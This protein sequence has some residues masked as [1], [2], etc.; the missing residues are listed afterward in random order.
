MK[1]HLKIVALSAITFVAGSAYA[2]TN[3]NTMNRPTP[4]GSAPSTTMSD[5]ANRPT[6]SGVGSKATG[7]DLAGSLASATD[8]STLQT[9]LVAAGLADKAKE[10][11]PFTVFAP[12]NAAFDKLPAGTLQS[13]TQPASKTKL[14]GILAYHVVPGNVMAADLKD[15][16]KIK[17]VSGGTLTVRKKGSAVMLVDAKG[18]SAMVTTADIQATNGTVHAIDSVLMPK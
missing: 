10:A 5:S 6:Q 9:A 1:K 17:T 12:S 14:Q 7:T 13:L 16:Q 11:G 15:G 4:V 18:G 2:Q 3:T 8:F